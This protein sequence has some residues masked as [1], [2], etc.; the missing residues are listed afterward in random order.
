VGSGFR[1]EGIVTD[2]EAMHGCWEVAWQAEAG[3]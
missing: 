2:K 3:G 1:E